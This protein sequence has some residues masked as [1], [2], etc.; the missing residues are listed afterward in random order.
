VRS[1]SAW[2]GLA[3]PVPQPERFSG[4]V[5]VHELSAAAD[6]EELEILAV[7]FD[8]GARTLPHI[9]RT[10][11]LLYF[12][13]GEGVVGTREA[14]RLYR[15]GGMAYIPAGEW[16]WHGATPTLAMGHLS[17]RPG[18]PSSWPPEVPLEDWDSYMASAQPG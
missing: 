14:R 12:L 17:I 11:Q 1:I 6:P 10:A 9:H 2:R 8:A 16:H 3:V 18:G 13:D 15:T 7:F 4:P 5:F